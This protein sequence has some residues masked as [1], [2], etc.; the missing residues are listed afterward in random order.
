[1]MNYTDIQDK[2]NE[3]IRYSQG[4]EEP[5][6]DRLFDTWLENKKH[7]IDKWGGLTYEIPNVSVEID[8]SK[9][10]SEMV[11]FA[12]RS[13]RLC[14]DDVRVAEFIMYQE[15]YAFYDNK[16]NEDFITTDNK[17]IPKGMKISKALK[18]FTKDKEILSELQTAYSMLI[19]EN[20][21]EG[22][23]VLS[24]HPLDFL[25][26]SENAH[27][28]RSCHAMDGEYRAGNLSYMQDKYTFVCYVKGKQDYSIPNFPFAW[29]SKKWRVLMYMRED[30]N[31]IMAGKQYPFENSELL[32]FA[33]E[34]G[35][36]EIY[37]GEWNEKWIKPPM[38]IV[39]AM[40][41]DE[42]GSLQFNDCLLSASYRPVIRFRD[43]EDMLENFTSEETKMLIGDGVECL[44]CG[45]GMVS[46]SGAV[47][48]EECG[49][50]VYCDCC[51]EAEYPGDMYT[52]GEDL[53][54][55][56]CYDE[57]STYCERC[58]SGFDNRTETIY[59]D[60]EDGCSYCDVCM[61]EIEAEREMEKK[62]NEACWM[63]EI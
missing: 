59:W 23:M 63:G 49:G 44:E 21:F 29:N 19:Q 26:M 36:C 20:K 10:Y 60:S 37:R 18:Y 28:W 40:I 5:L 50:Y 15:R 33:F 46:L 22:T 43:I 25:S 2:F 47:R 3:V 34:K 8:D 12:N 58:D 42:L 7:F 57:H 4:I 39:G 48:C 14:G 27:N 13:R 55:E 62:D 1:M 41:E 24:V 30:R 61:A 32:D 56:R 51:G 54:C 35:I 9:K 17:K 38:K 53:M 45:K 16:V 31:V 11:D 6:T 52:L